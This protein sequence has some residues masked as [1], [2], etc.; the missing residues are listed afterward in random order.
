MELGTTIN[1]NENETVRL[2]VGELKALKKWKKERM[3]ELPCSEIE[4]TEKELKYKPIIKHKNLLNLSKNLS[5]AEIR[6]VDIILANEYQ[7]QTFERREYKLSVKKYAQGSGISE[8]Q[9]YKDL[10]E[11]VERV[12]HSALIVELGTSSAFCRVMGSMC[13]DEKA[14]ELSFTW[15]PGIIPLLS[16]IM[17]KGSF[18]TF[19]NRMCKTSSST[20]YRFAELLQTQLYKNNF[21]LSI[22]NI[23]QFLGIENL[24]DDYRIF[25]RKLLIP[26][27]QD[28]KKYTGWNLDFKGIRVGRSIKELE[29]KVL[30]RYHP[31]VSW[32]GL[33]ENG[34]LDLD[35]YRTKYKRGI[36]MG[37]YEVGGFVDEPWMGDLEYVR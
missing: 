15:I 33:E 8:E 19:D 20:R 24:Y 31:K 9:A 12:F 29:F 7:L 16:G 21:V 2:T 34:E 1:E 36:M 18:N 30:G 23:K 25:R 11:I 6:L 4:T 3:E 5:I 10:K 14:H 17:P 35:K 37:D 22:D 27:L 26:T 32:V 28:L 13:L